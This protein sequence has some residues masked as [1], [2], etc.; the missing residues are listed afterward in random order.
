MSAAASAR[1]SARRVA[2][3]TQREREL[4]ADIEA[5]DLRANQLSAEVVAL[6]GRRAALDGYAAAGPIAGDQRFHEIAG[7]AAGGA[8]GSAVDAGPAAIRR[9]ARGLT[10]AAPGGSTPTIAALIELAAA[11]ISWAT[12]LSLSDGE[13]SARVPSWQ[14]RHEDAAARRTERTAAISE[15]RDG[16]VKALQVIAGTAAASILRGLARTPWDVLLAESGETLDVISAVCTESQ[17]PIGT[18]LADL[19]PEDRTQIL[20]ALAAR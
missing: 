20:R 17:V 4:G 18:R 15:V 16:N 3:N 5:L 2:A 10:A 12:V 19:T 14:G 6:T 1:R 11:A 13:S 7:L 8:V 9:A